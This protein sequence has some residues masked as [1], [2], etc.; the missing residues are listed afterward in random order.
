MI[1]RSLIPAYDGFAR[2]SG[3]SFLGRCGWESL[4]L[5]RF[6][7]KGATKT[8]RF[9]VFIFLYGLTLPVFLYNRYKY[10]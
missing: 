8:V 3:I 7:A 10:C 5:F 4:K 9:V 6:L 1:G 2:L